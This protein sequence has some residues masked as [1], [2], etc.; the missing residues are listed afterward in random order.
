M[1]HFVFVCSS[2]LGDSEDL[3]DIRVDAASPGPRVTFNIQDSFPEETEMDLLSVIIDGPSHYSSTSEGS[4]SVFGSPKTPAVFSPG[5]PFQPEEGRR[6]DSLSSSSED[7]EKEDDHERERTYFYRKPPS[8]S[9]KKATG[10]AAVHQLFTERW[11]TTPTNRSMTGTTTERNI[12]FELDIRVEIDCGKCVLH[13]T[14]LQ[15]EHD[16]ISLRRSYDRSSRSLD[17][18]SPS[19]K[20]KFQTNYASTSHLLA[21][22]KVPSSLQ[23]KSSEVET[24]VFYIPGVDVKLHYNSKT[25]KTESPNTS[26]G[27]SL[28]RTLSKESKLYGMKDTATSPLLS[29]TVHSKTNT[30]LPP[31]PPPIPSGTYSQ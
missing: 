12:D 5:I 10:F 7:S 13:P 11:P 17:R 1:L 2:R 18:E 8:T 9:R 30:L 23:T 14:T 25:L 31:Q 3:P 22:K 21:G 19:K 24:T 6:D 27:S 20:K 28:P 16:D 4:C 29:S 26:R 15:Q